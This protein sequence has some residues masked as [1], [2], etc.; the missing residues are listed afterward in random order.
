MISRARAGVLAELTG[1]LRRDFDAQAWSLILAAGLR[2]PAP[3]DAGSPVDDAPS[4]LPA[5][6]GRQGGRAVGAVHEPC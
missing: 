1:K 6:S 4:P 2:D 5:I 3:A